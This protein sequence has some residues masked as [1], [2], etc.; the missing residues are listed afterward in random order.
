MF[1]FHFDSFVKL[2][3]TYLMEQHLKS[4]IFAGNYLPFAYFL[5]YETEV[6]DFYEC[7]DFFLFSDS[8]YFCDLSLTF[9]Y[10]FFV[11]PE[12]KY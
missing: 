12:L 10:L 4:V 11:C 9:L 7:P 2:V 3:M 6:T 8:L 1:T 5:S